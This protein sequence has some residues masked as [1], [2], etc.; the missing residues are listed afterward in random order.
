MPEWE[1]RAR[2]L[3]Y[4]YYAGLTTE[5]KQ[6]LNETIANLRQQNA[7]PQEIRT[8]IQEKLEEFS[9]FDNQLNRTMSQTQLRLMILNREKELRAQG[10]NWSQVNA[11]IQEEFGQNATLGFNGCAQGSSTYS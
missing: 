6:E 5:Q 10:Y 8:A 11:M 9:V 7:T 4:P 3:P 2:G 1:H